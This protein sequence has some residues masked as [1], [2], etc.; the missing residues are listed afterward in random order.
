MLFRISGNITLV[1]LAQVLTGVCS[2][3]L[4]TTFES[5]LVSSVNKTFSNYPEYKAKFLKK[6]I[7][8]QNVLDAILSIT[9]STLCAMIY[10]L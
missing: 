5:W 2:G 3:L 4:S 7:K 10:V 1:Y 8:M 9:I 6:I